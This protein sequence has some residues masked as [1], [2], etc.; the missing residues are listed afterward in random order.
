[1]LIPKYDYVFTNTWSWSFL[2]GSNYI[3]DVGSTN[4]IAPNEPTFEYYINGTKV[5]DMPTVFIHPVKN[6]VKWSWF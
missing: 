2:G 3:G 5:H 4:Y 6:H 1:M